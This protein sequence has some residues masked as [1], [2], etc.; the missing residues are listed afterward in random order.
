MRACIRKGCLPDDY[1]ETCNKLARNGSYVLALAFKELPS[2]INARSIGGWDR[3]KVEND[4]TLVGLITFDNNVK[5][6][7]MIQC[8]WFGI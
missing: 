1:D 7:G 8:V 2:Q 6:R 4:L 3:S 5:V